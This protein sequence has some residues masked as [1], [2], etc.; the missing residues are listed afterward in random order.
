MREGDTTG[1]L[2]RR[3]GL[4]PEAFNPA[5]LMR[6]MKTT[7]WSF[8]RGDSRPP[9]N[10]NGQLPVPGIGAIAQ[11]GMSL[12]MVE[13]A[14]G[15]LMN[16]FRAL[17]A[18]MPHLRW[19]VSSLSW[20]V[21]RPLAGFR[22]LRAIRLEVWR[23][24][25]E[26][27]NSGLPLTILYAVGGEYQNKNYVLQL[28]FGES[29]RQR[30]LGRYWLSNVAKAIPASGCSLIVAEVCQSHLKFAGLSHWFLIPTW[31]FG[32]VDLPRDAKATEKV[33][34]DLR[35]IR[36]HALRCEVTRDPKQFDDFYYNMY[37]PYISRTF[38][39]CADV[40]PYKRMRAQFRYCDLLLVKNQEQSIAGQL[41]M[42]FKAGTCLGNMGIRDGNREYVKDGAGCAL[43]HFGLQY[44][45]DKGCKTA[46]LGWSRPFLRDGVLQFKKK[47]SQRIVDSNDNGFALGVAAYT[48]AVKAFLLNNPFI[49]KR[50]GQFHAAVFVDG[51]RPLSSADIE[52]VDKDYFHDG[53]SCLYIYV[54][55]PDNVAMPSPIPPSLVQRIEMR[56]TDG[57]FDM[58]GREVTHGR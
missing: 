13:L 47:W 15:S 34:G 14:G 42:N 36:R 8:A 37:V 22:W 11:P 32:E 4:H 35:R 29:Y 48:P 54:I 55:R 46:W 52:Q 27:R 40:S 20:V 7:R 56:A 2:P 30:R 18:L 45:Q 49:F 9:A 50:R 19:V 43:Y 12:W 21:S 25:G 24:E 53:L 44:L 6:C 16:P 17:A 58:C 28:I 1:N 51:D 57:L 38:G 3:L 5:I 33:S 23:V 41:V 31:V 26:E 10:Y 39:D